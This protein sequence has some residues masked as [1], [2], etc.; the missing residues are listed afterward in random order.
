MLKI[1]TRQQ[2][3][4]L[5]KYGRGFVLVDVRGRE[6]YE[7]EHIKGAISI[8]LDEIERRANQELRK[9]DLIV[10][11]CASFQCQ[12]STKAAEKL[13]SMGFTNI[14]DYKG[15]ML[16]YKSVPLELEGK[17][18]EHVGQEKSCCNC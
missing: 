3:V 10:T 1:V 11:Y 16:D 18:H 12:A 13:I 14:A 7:Q 6:L 8:P 15:G 2:I 17:L 5:M 9:E 4:D